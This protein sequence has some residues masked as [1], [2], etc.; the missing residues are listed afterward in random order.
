MEQFDRVTAT[1]APANMLTLKPDAAKHIGQR[2]EWMAAWIIEGGP[3][4]GQFAMQVQ[5]IPCPSFA[6][7]PLCDL[8]VIAQPEGMGRPLETQK[9][10]PHH[11][12]ERRKAHCWALGCKRVIRR[13]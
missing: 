8:E 4:D 13:G 11:K 10:P 9:A 1:F 12:A 2:F 3:Y 7:A 5:T 6:W